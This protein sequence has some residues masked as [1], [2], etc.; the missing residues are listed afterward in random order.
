[1]MQRGGEIVI[2]MLENVRQETIK[3]IITSTIT[4][5]TP[6]FTDDY[7]IYDRL[8][9][10][11]YERKSICHSDSEF[12]RDEGG[13]GF[14]EVHTNSVEGFWSL[15]GSWLRTHRGISQENLPLYLGFFEFIHNMLKRGK[16]L[17]SSLLVLL[18]APCF[19]Y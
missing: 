9:E 16:A 19:P 3:L 7:N 13:D 12:A 10:W 2:K 14:C 11:G 6:I 18:L 8:E 5:A 4:L 15:L 17:L 1:M